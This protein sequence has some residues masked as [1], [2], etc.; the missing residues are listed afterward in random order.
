MTSSNSEPSWRPN[1]CIAVVGEPQ[2][3]INAAMCNNHD[4][5]LVCIQVGDLSLVA[6]LC[7]AHQELALLMQDELNK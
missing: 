2:S 6:P 1:T 3:D 5:A 4:I 7:K